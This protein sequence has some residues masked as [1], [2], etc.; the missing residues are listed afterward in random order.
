MKNDNKLRTLV[1]TAMFA[2]LV[3]VATLVIR[4]PTVGGYTNLGDGIVL[5]SAFLLGPL[6]GGIAAGLG[7]ALAD[8][9]AGYAYYIPGT[10]IIKGLVA[11]F[12][13]LLM[14]KALQER[15]I[16]SVPMLLL[17]TAPAEL[18]MVAGYFAYKTLILGKPEG[19]VTSIAGNLM[20]GL[21]GCIISILLYRLLVKVP[22]V[23]ERSWKG[24]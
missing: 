6:Y 23:R 7:S 15:E 20:Q 4:I 24:R 5:L 17:C 16:P 18:F 21:V 2:A 1:L 19:A 9:I 14:K 10:F 8:L 3:C 13:A 12:A 11:V 22:A